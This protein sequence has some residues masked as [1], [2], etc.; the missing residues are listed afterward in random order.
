MGCRLARARCKRL[1]TT[2]ESIR[3]R[4]VLPLVAAHSGGRFRTCPFSSNLRFSLFI[5][6]VVKEVSDA[7][8]VSILIHRR[9][10]TT[11][12]S[13]ER[14]DTTDDQPDSEGINVRISWIRAV[15]CS[16]RW[17]STGD[18]GCDAAH[19]INTVPLLQFMRYG[20]RTL[21]P[22]SDRSLTYFDQVY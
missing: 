10:V 12:A 2:V 15:S 4:T 8:L 19:G 6:L 9:H 18:L 16:F 1:V 21:F 22:S 11:D 14:R 13:V 20:R 7:L 3:K 5:P 17:E